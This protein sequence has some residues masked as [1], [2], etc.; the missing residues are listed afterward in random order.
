MVNEMKKL[1]VLFMFCTCCQNKIDDQYSTS[2]KP[3]NSSN[4]IR[5]SIDHFNNSK[6]KKD[7]ID[8]F[9]ESIMTKK[10]TKLDSIEI[11]PEKLQQTNICRVIT[12]HEYPF[13]KNIK[14]FGNSKIPYIDSFTT[15]RGHEI[16][17]ICRTVIKENDDQNKPY[18]WYLVITRNGS[19]NTVLGWVHGYHIESFS[20][21]L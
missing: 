19:G 16:M 2:N 21:C 17:L 20:S 10:L 1:L 8:R 18:F 4:S 11:I 3:L 14:K 13:E 9:I 15:I 5:D 6:I 7:S 12:V